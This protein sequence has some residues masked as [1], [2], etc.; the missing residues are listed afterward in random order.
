[1]GSR[2][3]SSA[4]TQDVLLGNFSTIGVSFR[5]LMG[6]SS[7]EPAP[8]ERTDV[9]APRAD[10]DAP[11][12]RPGRRRGPH[13]VP[14][15]LAFLGM[16]TLGF[17]RT[18]IAGLAVSDVLFVAC[19]L[20]VAFKLLV[21]DTRNLA[22]PS[23]RR[24]PSLVL[25]GSIVLLT[26]G[27]LSSFNSW[28]PLGSMQVVLR[29]AWLTLVW[30]WVVRSVTRNRDALYKLLLGWRFAI[31]LSAVFAILG[32]IGIYQA[33]RL[34]GED[35]Q[36]AFFGHPNDL[37][38][39]LTFGLP[40]IVFDVPRRHGQ[41]AST[42]RRV[43]LTALVAYAVTTTGSM[44]AFLTMVVGLLAGAVAVPI[45]RGRFR[46]RRHSGFVSIALGTLAIAGLVVALNSEL[47][48]FQRFERYQQGD[49]GIE[50][51]I[52]SRDEKNDAVIGNLD[53]TLF[54]GTGLQLP[55]SG[56][57]TRVGDGAV[58]PDIVE[59]VHNMYLKL[60]Y[61]AGVPAFVGLLILILTAFRQARSAAMV[62]R[63]TDLYPVAVALLASIVA[64]NTMAQ[65]GPIA[66]QRY[67]WTPIAMTMCLWCLRR[68]ELR[69]E[70]AASL[71]MAQPGRETVTPRETQWRLTG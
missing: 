59:G 9:A 69:D 7:P 63:Q 64:S 67:Y 31:L 54:A 10:S 51:S 58:R 28:D 13:N 32:Q 56:D 33:G 61:E 21:G 30:F 65:F 3:A 19:A 5:Y 1:M 36:M 55:G 2:I 37:A 12:A 42:L 17:N 18:R 11:P 62:S 41:P 20:T 70:R 60:I 6:S 43:G 52:G 50:S 26:F 66:Y 45:S 22:R 8:W 34:E 35:R 48:V 39:L 53:E 27:S 14:L 71:G 38:S 47:P 15:L 16:A 44:T 4:A 49:S 46:L 68:E 40:L 57:V 23:I 25:I 29:F 24:T